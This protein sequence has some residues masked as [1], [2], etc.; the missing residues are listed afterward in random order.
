MRSLFTVPADYRMV[1]S[2]ASGLELRMLAHYV[3]DKD[4]THTITDGD[5]HS[6]HQEMAGLPTRDNAKSFIYAFLYGAGVTKLGEVIGGSRK[7]G[8]QLKDK[9][10]KANPKLAGLIGGVQK[11]ASDGFL[12]GLDGR[13]ITMRVFNNEIQTHKALNTLLQSAGATVMKYADIWLYEKV[14]ALGLDAHQVI[15][16]HD[17]T[18]WEVH[19]DDVK[20]F[21]S[22][23]NQW[24]RE[25]GEQLGMQC[26]L[27]S[28]AQVGLNWRDTH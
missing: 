12:E 14:K 28:D 21:I 3:N 27:A 23:G 20:Q 24:V 15:S 19:K 4:Y 13:R 18:Q 10:M 8:T 16:Y 2:D 11:S 5:I 17:E 26:P 7:A 9:F 25:A 6:M 1:G 22:L